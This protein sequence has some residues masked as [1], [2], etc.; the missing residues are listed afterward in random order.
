MSPVRL[1]R[2]TR[3]RRDD[4]GLL[5]IGR[6][7]PRSQPSVLAPN[8]AETPSPVTLESWENNHDFTIEER[9]PRRL[10]DWGRAGVDDGMMIG[11]VDVREVETLD[12]LSQ[13]ILSR[14]SNL[15]R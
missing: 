3:R 9:P 13:D 11:S 14:P 6:G 2:P 12:E 4:N 5:F 8:R 1:N 15:I 7:R 10:Q